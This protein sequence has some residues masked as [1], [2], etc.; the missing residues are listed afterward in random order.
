MF[1]LGSAV[2]LVLTVGSGVLYHLTIKGQSGGPG[3]GTPWA[4]LTAAY[5]VAFAVSAAAWAVLGGGGGAARVWAGP[6]LRVLL[7]GALLG[8]AA[9]GI[10]LGV[11]LAYRAGWA[12]GQ[13][14]IIN[15]GCVA[16]V[17]CVIG[18]VLS[19]ET[20]SATRA[21]GLVV[22]LGGVWLLAKG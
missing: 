18:V 3:G 6:D 4:F 1:G 9:L 2:P 19:G 10:E 8:L 7:A 15:A 17:L 16:A 21:A 14:S 22:A 11:L 13:L 12:M 20:M 5:A